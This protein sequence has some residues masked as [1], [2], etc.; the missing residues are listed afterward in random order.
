MFSR[1]TLLSS[2]VASLIVFS[3]CSDKQY[4]EPKEVDG[5]WKNRG[6]I[7]SSIVDISIDGAKLK[8]S[9]L[10]TKIGST[11]Y[12]VPK[13]YRFI[14]DSDNYYIS[15]TIDG[16][17]LFHPY[18]SFDKDFKHTTHNDTILELK[19]TVASVS[20]K[21]DIVAVLFSSNEM[22]LYSLET[23]KQLFS[24]EGNPPIVVDARMANPYFFNDLVL[25]QTLDG[26][27]VIVNS[28][29][30]KVLRSIIVSSDEFFNNIIYFNMIDNQMI[31]ATGTTL[32]SFGAREI[33]EDYNIRDAIFNDD[34]VWI[35][36]KEGQL[37]SLTPSLQVK[38]RLKFPFAQFTGLV[39][40]DDHVYALEKQ[41][42][43]I[44]ANKELSSSKV[45][46][47]DTDDGFVFTANK[48]F[49][50]DDTF[51]LTDD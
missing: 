14:S 15:G 31:V 12:S 9:K 2:L 17:L 13:G 42:Y 48:A 22:A 7:D 41:G 8:N 51:I 32:L 49:V 39:V 11:S 26:K 45:Y 36:T 3:G 6:K 30:K 29:T 46:E 24:N 25:F 4:Y 37:I 10:I 27:V 50:I 47:T 35:A 20:I 16:K 38:K 18:D 21:G 19:K 1:K 5:E 40:T 34:G 28:D 23:K 43:L 33:R 44:V